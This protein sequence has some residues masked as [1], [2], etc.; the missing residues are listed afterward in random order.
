[1]NLAQLYTKSVSLETRAAQEAYEKASKR[2]NSKAQPPRFITRLQGKAKADT[3]IVAPVPTDAEFDAN[4]AWCSA[5]AV[6]FFRFLSRTSCEYDHSDYLIAPCLFTGSKPAKGNHE[7]VSELVEAA[8]EASH[9]KRFIVVGGVPFRLHFGRG[10]AVDPAVASGVIL[11]PDLLRGKPLYMF[12][13]F[14]PFSYTDEYIESLNYFGKNAIERDQKKLTMLMES[15]CLPNFSRFMETE[16]S[17][18]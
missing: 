10:K 16:R 12:P 7:P 14:K 2:K 5:S 9:I 4:L 18:F 13:D 1:M 11:Y 3:L 6:A 17:L 15:E 8:V